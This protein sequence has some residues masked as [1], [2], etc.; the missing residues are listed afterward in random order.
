MRAVLIAALLVAACGERAL[1]SEGAEC[2]ASSEC[3]PNLVCDFGADPHVCSTMGTP[4][5]PDPADASNLPAA[6][7]DPNAPDASDLPPDFDAAAPVFDAA[8]F[9][10]PPPPI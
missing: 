10:A 8:S 1:K 5:D 3:A 9:D 7:A 6:D 2:F 4:G